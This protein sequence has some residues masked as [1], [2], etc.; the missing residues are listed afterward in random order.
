[1]K[2]VFINALG[3][4]FIFKAMDIDYQSCPPSYKLANDLNKTMGLHS[5]IHVN[6]FFG[7]KL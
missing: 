7:V 1:M 5:T 2:N 4:T 6:N 3:P